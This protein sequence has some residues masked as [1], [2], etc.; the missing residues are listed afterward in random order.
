METKTS[1]KVKGTIK[2]KPHMYEYTEKNKHA[3]KI[4][5]LCIDLTHLS[6]D[7]DLKYDKEIQRCYK[8]LDKLHDRVVLDARNRTLMMEEAGK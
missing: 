1:L 7:T 3:R 2:D 6:G 5:E 8:I 4:H